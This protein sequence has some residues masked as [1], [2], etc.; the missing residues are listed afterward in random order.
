[1][2]NQEVQLGQPV[3]FEAEAVG[4]PVPMMSWQKDGKML[5]SD[6]RYRI[7]TDGGHSALQIAAAQKDDNAWFQC[8]A[9]SAAG[10]ATNRARLTV[11]G[12]FG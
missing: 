7:H 3:R 9:A 2:E 6:D 1:M 4:V 10:M 12:R 5:S 11:L 8:T